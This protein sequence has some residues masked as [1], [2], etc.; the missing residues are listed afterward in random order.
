MFD[1]HLDNSTDIELLVV[2]QL[3]VPVSELVRPFDL[4]R[5]TLTMPQKELFRKGYGGEPHSHELE[6]ARR[7]VAAD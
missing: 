2:G 1:E 5:H 6:S 3:P 4:P 7:V